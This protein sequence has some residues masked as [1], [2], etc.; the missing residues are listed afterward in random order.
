MPDE[1]QPDAAHVV[2]QGRPM[3]QDE[4]DLMNQY[5]AAFIPLAR[6]K[7]TDDVAKWIFTITSIVGTL[8]VGFNSTAFK[9]AGFSSVV[10]GSAIA[11]L[12]ISLA[13]A[14]IC[15]GLDVGTA[16]IASLDSMTEE[17]R[18][19]LR[20]KRIL[21]GLSCGAFSLALVVAA[22]APVLSG[23]QVEKP[24][25]SYTLNGKSFAFTAR[26]HHSLGSQIEVKV[27]G[28]EKQDVGTPLF[29][30]ISPDT[31]EYF[32]V[33][34]TGINIAMDNLKPICLRIVS[35]NYPT[36]KTVDQFAIPLSEAAKSWCT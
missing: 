15:V 11:I 17:A 36:D 29:S 32:D 21:V 14:A 22:L 7:A 10:F 9:I 5:R 31:G 1:A 30:A 12:G 23:I 20:T 8:A 33:Q 2:I 34:A 4:I 6:L 35:T 27:T 24:N 28:Y 3:A 13:L 16:S 26:Y 25:V 18:R 19:R